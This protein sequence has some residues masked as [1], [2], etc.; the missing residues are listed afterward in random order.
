MALLEPGDGRS[1]D[2][3]RQMLANLPPGGSIVRFTYQRPQSN[4]MAFRSA[5]EE[6]VAVVFRHHALT[7]SIRVEGYGEGTSSPLGW[8]NVKFKAIS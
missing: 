4:T 1:W 2:D 8:V 3:V 5:I 7:L 6:M